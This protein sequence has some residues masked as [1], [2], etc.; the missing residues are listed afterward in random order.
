MPSKLDFATRPSALARWQ[1]RHVIALLA[2]RWPDLACQEVLFTTAGDRKLDV[3]LP[4]I[5]GK[6]LFT[7]ELEQALLQEKVDAAVHSL[8]DLPTEATPGLVIGAIPARADAQD[9]WICP[10]GY[11]IDQLPPG[12]VVGTSSLRRQ[13]QLLA[14]RPDLRVE[15]VRGNVD[16]R[17][18]K[19]QE[20]QYAA[21]LLA[22]AGV[23]RLELWEHVTQ[24]LPVDLMLPAPG[25]GALAVQCRAWDEET[26]QLVTPLD[27]GP[28]RQAV[29]AERA[30][31]AA[32][33][34]GCSLPVGAL[35]TLEGDTIHL[36]GV[37]AAPDGSRIL[38]LV[39]TGED[40]RTVG[41]ALARQAL[42]EGAGDLLA[43]RPKD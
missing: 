37:V 4:E 21:I 24:V 2:A 28:T 40:A 16:T 15:T 41:E 42:A 8:K 20:G 9:V 6:G 39:A 3:A 7:E 26:L 17:I 35:A 11:S 34:T 14:Y 22:A 1:T 38:R 5:G 10:A 19:A 33:G 43:A 18:R 29:V 27:H 25:Q 13:A 32:L 12:S 23:R 31:L 30:F 36:R